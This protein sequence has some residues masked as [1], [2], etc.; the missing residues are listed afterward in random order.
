MRVIVLILGWLFWGMLYRHYF[1]VEY[2]LGRDDKIIFVFLFFY[3]F[4]LDITKKY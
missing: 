2:S 4:I 1:G 3:A